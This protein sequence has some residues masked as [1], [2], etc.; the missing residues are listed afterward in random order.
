MMHDEDGSFTAFVAALA[1]ALFALVGLVVDSGRAIA[2]HSAAMDQAEQAARAGA[3]QLSIDALRS[4]QIAVDPMAAI[5]AA[6]GY[7][8][9][10]G[11]TGGASVSG[12]VVTVRIDEMEPTVILQMVGIDTINISVVASATDVHGI[13]RQD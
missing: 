11:D 3:G 5:R 13:A 7:L 1:V 12:N 6:D 9:T 10:V 8:K 4:G 2:A